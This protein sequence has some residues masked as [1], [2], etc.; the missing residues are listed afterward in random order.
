MSLSKVVGFFCLP[1]SYLMGPSLHQDQWG[2][3]MPGQISVVEEMVEPVSP[4]KSLPEPVPSDEEV[5]WVS[6]GSAMQ[7]PFQLPGPAMPSE[8]K[9]LS[10]NKSR[11]RR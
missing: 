7:G 8:W 3:G 9:L 10:S 2:T 4:L 11:P 6:S 5:M 1:H